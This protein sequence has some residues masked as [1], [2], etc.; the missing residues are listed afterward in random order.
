MSSQPISDL[1]AKF[2]HWQCLNR[3]YAAR[4]A[5]G[6]PVE[7]AT[8]LIC[9]GSDGDTGIELSVLILKY[10][11]SNLIA[12]YRHN[13]KKTADPI[14]R[15][16]WVVKQTS[17]EYYQKPKSFQSTLTALCPADAPFVEKLLS[18]GNCRMVFRGNSDGYVLPATT[19]VLASDDARAE[20]T[21]LHNFHFNHKQPQPNV[22]LGFEPDWEAGYQLDKQS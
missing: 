19:K 7:A 1:Q 16:E 2:M 11:L 4:Q 12:Q 3:L 22:I 8:P 6:F 13:A 21:T 14:E 9:Y 10:D 18:S 5:A 17:A 20:F 15:L